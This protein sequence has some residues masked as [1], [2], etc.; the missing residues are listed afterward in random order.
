[1]LTEAISQYM[2]KNG[3]SEKNI[4]ELDDVLENIY[5]E[6]KE[7]DV[8]IIQY[9]II[10]D[11]ISGIDIEQII[12]EVKDGKFLFNHSVYDDYEKKIRESDDFAENPTLNTENNIICKHCKSKKTF[13]FQKQM[14]SA[15]EPMSTITSCNS[16]GKQSRTDG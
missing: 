3:V 1:M 15:D 14:R 4:S 11:F 13:S 10:G 8:D 9:D 2:I 7:I 6:N 12:C 16:C 5:S